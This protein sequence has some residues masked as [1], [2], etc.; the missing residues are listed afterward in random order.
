MGMAF[1]AR[2]GGEMRGLFDPLT[3]IVAAGAAGDLGDAVEHADE[4]SLTTSV[5]GRRTRVCGIE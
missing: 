1:L 3:A 5:S 2:E 4:V